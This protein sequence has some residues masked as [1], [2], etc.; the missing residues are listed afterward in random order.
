MT[1]S[2]AQVILFTRDEL[3][4]DMSWLRKHGMITDGEHKIL[5]DCKVTRGSCV[6]PSI[7]A[8]WLTQRIKMFTDMGHGCVPAPS[9]AQSGQCRQRQHPVPHPSTSTAAPVRQD[10]TASSSPP[11]CGSPCAQGTLC[12]LRHSVTTKPPIATRHPHTMG[13]CDPALPTVC[14]W[15]VW[16]WLGV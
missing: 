13:H 3:E 11:R 2:L 14:L 12:C 10:T 7:I 6:A 1:D 8:T 5:V 15:V 9:S 16:F 4:E